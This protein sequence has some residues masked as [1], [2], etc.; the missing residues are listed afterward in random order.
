MTI[1]LLVAAS[2]NNGIG[3]QNQLPWHLPAD[4]KYF[5]NTTWGMP[6]IMGRKTFESMGNR[7][8]PGRINIIITRQE[9]YTAA[10]ILVAN[11]FDDAIQIAAQTDCR[12]VFVIGGGEIFETAMASAQKLYITRVHSTI[13]ADVFFPEIDER[14]WDMISSRHMP[15]DDKHAFSFSFQLWQ[16]KP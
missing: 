12:E 11:S 2:E 5:K 3:I 13:T 6:I 1:S 7:A 14:H 8:L 4:M 16:H 9:D 10:G 15:A